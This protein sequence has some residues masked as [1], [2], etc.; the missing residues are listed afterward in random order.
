MVKQRW[1]S[2]R[3]QV[4]SSIQIGEMSCFNQHKAVEFEYRFAYSK[5]L[6]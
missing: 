6:C 2:L 3:Q 4:T 1:T 5:F